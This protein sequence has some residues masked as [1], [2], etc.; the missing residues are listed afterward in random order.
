MSLN[1][2]QEQFC[3]EY[4]ATGQSMKSAIAAG[5]SPASAHVQASD[6]LKNPKIQARIAEIKSPHL[7]KLGITQERVLQEVARLAFF[8]PR[9][10]FHDDGSPR[11]I[12]E[13]DDDTAAA[14]SGIDVLDQYEGSGQSREYVGTLKKYRVISKDSSLE[15]LM[16]YLGLLVDRAEVGVQQVVVQTNVSEEDV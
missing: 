1:A 5:Y 4:V 16:K 15:K 14:I 13:L 8:D 7:T 3:Q 6:L 9:K 2:R 11:C 12:S 10:L